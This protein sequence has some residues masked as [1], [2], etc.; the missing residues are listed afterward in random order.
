MLTP[1]VTIPGDY[2]WYATDQEPE[3]KIRN[4]ADFANTP[5][6][7]D[8]T[9]IQ[10]HRWLEQGNEGGPIGSWVIAE[11]F[12]VRR[13]DF[14]GRTDVMVEAPYWNKNKQAFE[15]FNLPQVARGKKAP[16]GVIKSGLPVNLTTAPPS[17]VVD[18]DGGPRLNVR[19][20]KESV[21]SDASAVDMLVLTPEGDLIV[22]NSRRDTDPEAPEGEERNERY[23]QWR[24]RLAELRAGGGRPAL[25]G[26]MGP[27]MMP[28][29]GG[30][31]GGMP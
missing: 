21:S 8:M 18:Y 28:M 26:M 1:E 17:L 9:P 4:G 27:G 7:S 13:G 23:E 29:P 20:G 16:K 30:V 25:P 15:I 10:V 22:R 31:P 24:D 14:V 12:W 3:V 2:F 11:R 5:P 6:R 19:I